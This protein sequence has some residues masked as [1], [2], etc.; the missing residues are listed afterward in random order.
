M[1]IVVGIGILAA[2][3]LPQFMQQS[4]N[5]K[6]SEARLILKQIYTNEQA[7]RQKGVVNSYFIPGGVADSSNRFALNEIWI[8]LPPGAKYSYRISGGTNT[9][10]ATAKANIDGDTTVDTWVMTEGGNLV[11]T[12]NDVLN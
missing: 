7:Y 9:F 6:Q 12:V 8:E 3:L 1:I 4:T 5:S 10:T 11:N 2:I